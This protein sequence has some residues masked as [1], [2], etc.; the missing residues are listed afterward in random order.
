M[1]ISGID[2]NINYKA[3]EIYVSGCDGACEGCHNEELW[4][5]SAGKDWLFYEKKLRQK[6]STGMVSAVW[7][8]GGEPLLQDLNELEFFLKWVSQYKKQIMLWTRFYEIPDN[9]KKYIKYAKVGEYQKDSD[10]YEEP[11]FGIELASGNQKIIK[12]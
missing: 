6:L 1:N 12:V 11:L 4:D 3:L 8:M 9:I 2:Y 10:S 7:V 5:F